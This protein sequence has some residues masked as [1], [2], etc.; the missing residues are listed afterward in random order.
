[1]DRRRQ[2]LWIDGLAA[3]VAGVVVL[4][5][6]GWLSEFYRLPRG[7]LVFTGIVN[8]IYASYSLPLAAREKRPKTFITF[9][10]AANLFWAMVC[11]AL[12]IVYGKDAGLFGLLH[13]WGEAIFVGGLAGLEWRWR[14]L[15]RTA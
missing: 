15:L 5:L 1:M 13:L 11:V 3:L 12:A 8:L 10:V 4:S 6:S 7:V 14:D 9:L 2:I